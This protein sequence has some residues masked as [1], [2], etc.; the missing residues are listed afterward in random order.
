MSSLLNLV[1]YCNLGAT[2]EFPSEASHGCLGKTSKFL[3]VDKT[4]LGNIGDLFVKCM[5]QVTKGHL[6]H[7]LGGIR[8]LCNV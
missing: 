5:R 6:C 3:T 1:Q 8:S 4:M 2:S 7:R